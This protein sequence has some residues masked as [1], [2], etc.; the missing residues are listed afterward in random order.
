M[1]VLFGGVGRESGRIGR[2]IMA[3][4][5]LSNLKLRVGES[6]KE[7]F[8]IAERSLKSKPAYFRILKK[9]LDARNKNDLRYIY[10]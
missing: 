6:E 4:Q 10:D 2:K 9:S 8:K 5:T 7:L 3:K 1:G